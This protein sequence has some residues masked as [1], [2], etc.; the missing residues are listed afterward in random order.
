MTPEEIRR[1]RKAKALSQEE[2]GR[3]CGVTKSAVSQ[4]EKGVNGPT[5]SALILLEE[6]LSGTRCIVPLTQQEEK[7]LDQNVQQGNFATRE[8]F[9]AA[10][11]VHLLR[12]GSFDV[13]VRIAPGNASPEPKG[14]QR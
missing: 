10:S 9:L 5:G 6:F 1:F 4:W 8:D 3:L 14:E 11:L 12:H 2:L 7:L 13:P